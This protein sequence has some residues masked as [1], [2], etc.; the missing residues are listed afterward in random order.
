[1]FPQIPGV[2]FNDGFTGFGPIDDSIFYNS[3]ASG[4]GLAQQLCLIQYHLC[5][6]GR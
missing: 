6:I 2:V 4:N 5:L 1:L 3:D